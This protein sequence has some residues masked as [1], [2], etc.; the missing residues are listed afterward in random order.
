LLARVFV[1]MIVVVL[2]AL[3]VFLVFCVEYLM[4]IVF[5]FLVIGCLDGS[6]VF[7]AMPM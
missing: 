4:E 6:L 3:V 2:F 1:V 7:F 5:V